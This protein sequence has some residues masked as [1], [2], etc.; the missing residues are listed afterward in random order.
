MKYL[1]RSFNPY[2]LRHLRTT[3][4]KFLAEF[5]VLDRLFADV[6][7]YTADPE[8]RETA[9]G[10]DDEQLRTCAREAYRKLYES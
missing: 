7:D 5:K 4:I 8:L 1:L 3:E 9:G 6:D 10:L 2:T